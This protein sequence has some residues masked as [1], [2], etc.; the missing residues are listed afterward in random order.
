MDAAEKISVEDEAVDK[1]IFKD[2]SKI[3]FYRRQKQRLSK[4]STYR[5]LLD[6]VTEGK[7]STRFQI[8]NEA[9][10]A[11][12]Q[13]QSPPA[14]DAFKGKEA[15]VQEDPQELSARQH[16]AQKGA[17]E[18]DKQGQVIQ[19]V[20]NVAPK[21]EN[22]EDPL[23]QTQ[24]S[25]CLQ[26]FTGDNTSGSFSKGAG[27]SL[28]T[29]MKLSLASSSKNGTLPNQPP[30]QQMRNNYYLL[31]RTVS[32]EMARNRQLIG[33]LAKQSEAYLDRLIVLGEHANAQRE[34]ASVLHRESVL[35]IN[36]LAT[37]MEGAISA[38][39]QFNELDHSLNPGRS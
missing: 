33:E 8:I 35:A 37:T 20:S 12:C 23:E 14:M 9:A 24:C 26:V 3:A 7:E 32:A 18:P 21:T 22:S 11:R 4:K 30:P 34:L 39:Q 10:K 15:T 2:C 6:S 27:I 36:Q 5:A 19:D 13:N 17:E 16:T 28:S 31:T 29:S 1:K 38:L 25:A